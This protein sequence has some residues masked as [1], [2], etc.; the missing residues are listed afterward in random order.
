M[1]R[2][3]LPGIDA[4]GQFLPET[5]RFTGGT[6]DLFYT[7]SPVLPSDL[8]L[9]LTTG[10]ITGTVPTSAAG[11]SYIITASNGGGVAPATLT[12]LSPR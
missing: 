6:T 2:L 10:V 11:L 7:S 8:R 4:E 1:G 5:Y 12:V 3:G 9:D